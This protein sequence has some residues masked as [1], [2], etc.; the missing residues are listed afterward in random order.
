LK[1]T[2]PS[3]GQTITLPDGTPQADVAEAVDMAVK[4]YQPPTPQQTA[5]APAP[6]VTQK[7]SPEKVGMWDKIVGTV[8][9]VAAGVN[10]G[11]NTLHLSV[12]GKNSDNFTRNAQ[13]WRDK[14]TEN[15]IDPNSLVGKVAEGAGT[16]PAA[17]PEWLPSVPGIAVGTALSANRGYHTVDPKTGEE[18]GVTGALFEGGKHLAFRATF[19]VIDKIPV[20]KIFSSSKV[21]QV[22]TKPVIMGGV[23]GGEAA[24]QGGDAKDIAAATILGTAVPMMSHLGG[25]RKAEVKPEEIRSGIQADL[26][27]KGVPTEVAA[28]LGKKAAEIDSSDPRNVDVFTEQLDEVVKIAKE[29]APP[30]EP[31]QPHEMTKSE[32]ANQPKDE[33]LPNG[34]FYVGK[35]EVI[36]NPTPRDYAQLKKE[37][38]D[39]YP[40]DTDTT[41]RFTEDG[42]GN[43]FI[44]K[45]YEAVHSQIEPTIAK[46]LGREVS[47]NPTTQSPHEHLRAVY[48][49]LKEGKSV[50]EEVLNE[51][52]NDGTLAPLIEAHRATKASAEVSPKEKKYVPYEFT[53][54]ERVSLHDEVN[55]IVNEDGTVN[56]DVESL[57]NLS[58]VGQTEQQAAIHQ[59]IGE[60]VRNKVSERLGAD[61]G[62]LDVIRDKVYE[63]IAKRNSADTGMDLLK[64][65]DN[66]SLSKQQTA[67]DSQVIR[68]TAAAYVKL[69]DKYALEANKDGASEAAK[70]LY[71]HYRERAANF[72][73][74]DAELARQASWELN[75]RK[76]EATGESVDVNDLTLAD[77]E[78]NPA[79]MD[80]LKADAEISGGM[81]AVNKMVEAHLK[82][83]ELP[84]KIKAVRQAHSPTMLNVIMELRSMDLLSSLYGR[85]RDT[86]HNIFRPVSEMAEHTI[87]AGVSKVRGRTGADATPIEEV[88]ARF[89][90]NIDGTMEAVTRTIGEVSKLP[91]ALKDMDTPYK[92]LYESIEAAEGHVDSAGFMHGKTKAVLEGVGR[93]YIR[94]SYIK[95]TT[96]GHIA[97]KFLRGLGDIVGQGETVSSAAWKVVDL[98]GSIGRTAVYGTIKFTDLPSEYMGYNSEVYGQATKVAVE[99]GLS[100]SAAR[101]LSARLISQAKA[102]RDGI[103][104]PDSETRVDRTLVREIHD[105]GMKYALD[106]TLKGE[107]EG[108]QA[109][110]VEA[111]LNHSAAG[112]VAKLAVNQFFSTTARLIKYEMQRNVLTAW[113]SKGMRDSMSG[114]KGARAQDLATAKL[115]FGTMAHTAAVS[116]VMN[117][118]ITGVA[119]KKKEA[120]DAGVLDVALNINGRL[121]QLNQADPYGGF[122]TSVAS[123]IYSAK[124]V[125]NEGTGDYLSSMFGAMVNDRLQRRWMKSLLDIKMAALDNTGKG[126]I[127]YLQNY[128]ATLLP[129]SGLITSTRDMLGNG[130]VKAANGMADRVMKVY[131]PDSLDTEP[132]LYGKTR[133]S[134]DRV[135]GLQTSKPDMKSARM[136]ILKHN[137]KMPE[138]PDI[139]T[140]IPGSKFGH[141]MDDK[142]KRDYMKS[143]ADPKLPIQMERRLQEVVDS[144]KYSTMAP[145]I[146]EM[147]L[148]KIVDSSHQ[149]AQGLLFRN[150]EIVD[151]ARNKAN[152][153]GKLMNDHT[154]LTW[155]DNWLQFLTGKQEAER[156]IMNKEGLKV[157]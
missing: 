115:I 123:A 3:T 112:K 76:N 42:Q 139:M 24:I 130:E 22:V 1:V 156:G 14:A 144:P 127:K 30:V 45:A 8:E 17:L 85:T 69:V 137:I 2:I 95:K 152:A 86:L 54:E 128:G 27:A 37:S 110:D 116:L 105:A 142:A 134:V 82:A 4:A 113:T 5:P 50:P 98:A 138:A 35:T 62:Q 44:W 151:S 91:S 6:A 29:Q 93:K 21:A 78:G 146:Q 126:W 20:A 92:M 96:T 90:G 100:G 136:E 120:R 94:S 63:A 65:G 66:A 49:A 104:L 7:A 56:P 48:S 51:Y 143:L 59:A 13:Y 77:L 109:K 10:Q 114:A 43:R 153:M 74:L 79:L 64:M 46:M 68:E 40:N 75:S 12:F 67:I 83:A 57:I 52:Q 111:F 147:W 36:Q 125:H 119:T 73:A 154:D 28:E 117:G 155:K 88:G 124:T 89:L 11:A 135:W 19:G 58:R 60:A 61:S 72:V 84:D 15:G 150:P 129:M 157:K 106:V 9:Q 32:Y 18:G 99:R 145:E 97:D 25:G 133:H 70:L 71:L 39:K 26:E 16:V 131:S 108:Q 121:Y 53:P 41:I 122:L 118:V 102:L 103:K 149:M 81:E 31:K 47:Q 101:D 87:A 132:D 55:K 141:T 148:K 140:L 80:A 34:V 107:M 23:M 38:R 33:P